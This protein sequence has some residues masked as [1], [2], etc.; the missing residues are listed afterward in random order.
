M[1]SGSASSPRPAP[2]ENEFPFGCPPTICQNP[3]EPKPLCCT[4]CLPENVR[5]LCRVEGELLGP[6]G[7]LT[8][9]VAC[10]DCLDILKTQLPWPQSAHKVI[11]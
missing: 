1:A 5:R 10:A 11:F 9:C 7:P 2:D 6:A 3:A 8:Y 4:V